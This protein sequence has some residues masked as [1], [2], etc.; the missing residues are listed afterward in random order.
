MVFCFC[1]QVNNLVD[2][3]LPL[4]VFPGWQCS[5]KLGV[6]DPPGTSQIH[7]EQIIDE[8]RDF[9][10]LLKIRAYSPSMEFISDIVCLECFVVRIG[11]VIEVIKKLPDSVE[12]LYNSRI[13]TPVKK[14]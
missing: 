12:A 7:L 2:K 1:F 13:N 3:I 4:R 11:P 8:S 6:F 5:L 9:Q 14:L 10:Q